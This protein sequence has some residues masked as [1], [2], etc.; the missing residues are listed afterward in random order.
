MSP[1]IHGNHGRKPFN[2]LPLDIYQHATHFVQTFIEKHV[3]TDGK[4]KVSNKTCYRL[5]SEYTKKTLHDEYRQFCQQSM[6]STKIMQYS[7]FTSFFK[8]Q[9]PNVKFRK[10]DKVS[11]RRPV[12]VPANDW[13][14][15]KRLIK[16][17]DLAVQ[18]A[19]DTLDKRNFSS[20]FVILGPTEVVLDAN[21][22]IILQRPE[23]ISG[24]YLGH[25]VG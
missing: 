21:A 20:P 23:E 3:K 2:T 4:G 15:K 11:D 13:N 19:S 16:K 8:K 17:R 9:F 18:T 1:R 12:D 22:S 6:P 14:K 7:T 10:G 25:D 5:P 24:H